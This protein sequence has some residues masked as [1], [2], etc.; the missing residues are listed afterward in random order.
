[1]LPFS[2]LGTDTAVSITW[3]PMIFMTAGLTSFFVHSTAI[4]V[5]YGREG[6]GEKS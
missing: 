5:Q 1:M 2:I 4:L 6:K 3:L